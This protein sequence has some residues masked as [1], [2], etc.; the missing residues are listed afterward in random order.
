MKYARFPSDFTMKQ[1]A[2]TIL[3]GKSFAAYFLLIK[4]LLKG[5]LLNLKNFQ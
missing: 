2:T 1:R 5:M 4:S 3:N